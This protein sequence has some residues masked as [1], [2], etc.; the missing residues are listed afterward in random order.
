MKKEL[1]REIYLGN[2]QPFHSAQPET[3]KISYI[4]EE[5]KEICSKIAKAKD[6]DEEQI[7][8]MVEMEDY[9]N[10]LVDEYGVYYFTAGIKFW[11]DISLELSDDSLY[12]V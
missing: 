4:K 8:L 2:F 7:Q 11:H 10:R 3:Q 1:I 5:I 6:N 9:I 12:N